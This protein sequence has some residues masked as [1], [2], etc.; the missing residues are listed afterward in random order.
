[1]AY[2]D[3][4]TSAHKAVCTALNAANI[5]P[6]TVKVSGWGNAYID[7]DAAYTSVAGKTVVLNGIM[8]ALPEPGEPLGGAI[9]NGYDLYINGLLKAHVE[10]PS[11]D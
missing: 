3:S 1:M 5:Y 9:P 6:E 11:W 2:I 8:Q 4:I 10:S 7:F